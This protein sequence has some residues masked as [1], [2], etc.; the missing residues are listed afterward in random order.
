MTA[1][2]L[3][4]LL[5]VLKRSMDNGLRPGIV[6]VVPLSVLIQQTNYQGA[7]RVCVQVIPSELSKPLV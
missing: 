6:V 2:F 7:L 4:L 5:I 1:Y 3:S